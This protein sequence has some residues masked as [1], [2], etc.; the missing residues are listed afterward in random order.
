MAQTLVVHPGP[1]GDVLL[2]VPAMRALRRRHGPELVLAAQSHVGEL[3]HILGIV[4]VRIRFD[5][6]GLDRLF[7]EG[8]LDERAAVLANAD[9]LV[10]WF[11]SKDPTFTKRLREIAPR[12]VVAP[13]WVVDRLVWQHLLT[14]IGEESEGAD[15][16]PIGLPARLVAD[17]RHALQAAG[18][19]GTLPLVI[20][21][22]GSSGTSKRWASEGYA[23]VIGGLRARTAVTVVIHQG[24]TDREAVRALLGHLPAPAAVLDNPPLT[25]LASALAHARAFV[26]NDSGVSHLAAAVGAPALV[27]FTAA[28]R[29]WEPWSRRARSLMVSTT[30]QYRDDVDAVA[31]GLARLVG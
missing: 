15:R 31:A 17:G 29:A 24:P 5:L 30:G 22:P 21:H 19:D 9:R 23:A 20:V 16:D 4:D 28:M 11:G 18:W 13:P 25:V 1:L 7:V 27:L 26:G 10:C 2:A 3:L 12:C 8:P 14:T 6:L